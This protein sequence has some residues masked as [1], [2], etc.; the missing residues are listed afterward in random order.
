MKIFIQIRQF[1]ALIIK[2]RAAILTLAKREFEA[3][4]KGAYLGIVWSYIQPLTYIV[5][6]VLVFSIGLRANPGGKVPFVVFLIS[7]MIPWHFFSGTLNSVT[8]VVKTHAFLVRKGDYSLSILHVAHILSKLIS[9]LALMGVCLLVAWHYGLPP[10]LITLQ[11]FYYIAA[12]CLLL[13]G[14]GW[15]TSAASLFVEDV[16][17]VVSIF[18]QFGFWLTPILWNISR[19]PAKYQWIV[20]LNPAH[21]IVQGYRE[22]VIDHIPFWNNLPE[23]V[24]FWCFTLVML[25]I[26]VVVFRR[27]KPHFGEVI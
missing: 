24:Y 23:T 20:K 16:S 15:I 7:G 19:I 9:H 3:G 27:L 12:Q 10:G 22:T 18:T 5:V 13:L 1:L 4:S 17:N 2:K 26:G 14:L 11:L 8:N 6:L 25:N 21:Y